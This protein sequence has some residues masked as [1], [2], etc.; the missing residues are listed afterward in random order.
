MLYCLQCWH[1]NNEKKKKG[2]RSTRQCVSS[3]AVEFPHRQLTYTIW[4][5]LKPEQCEKLPRG[6]GSLLLHHISSGAAEF[7]FRNVSFHFSSSFLVR[8][9]L[10]CSGWRVSRGSAEA[11]DGAPSSTRFSLIKWE[12]WKIAFRAES[13]LSAAPTLIFPPLPLPFFVWSRC[14][15]ACAALL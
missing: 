10:F 13:K 2:I 9:R 5:T 4:D 1:E 11:T 8:P 15:K 14:F 7:D 12:T 3:V 6:I